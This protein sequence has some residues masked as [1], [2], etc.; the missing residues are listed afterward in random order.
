[1]S[2]WYNMFGPSVLA[3]TCGATLLHAAVRRNGPL[4]DGLRW[5]T[6]NENSQKCADWIIGTGDDWPWWVQ[7]LTWGVAIRGQWLGLR[8]LRS[9]LNL[10]RNCHAHCE[11]KIIEIGG[12]NDWWIVLWTKIGDFWSPKLLLGLSARSCWGSLLQSS[13]SLAGGELPRNPTP[14]LGPFG[15]RLWPF[16][17]FLRE[18]P[19]ANLYHFNHCMTASE[20]FHHKND[21]IY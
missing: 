1:M 12:Q 13:Y 4:C 6:V 19:P 17:P 20:C 7:W 21:C 2:V 3:R 11:C 10:A 9:K 18:T 8:L 14:T 16:V 15:L 5:W